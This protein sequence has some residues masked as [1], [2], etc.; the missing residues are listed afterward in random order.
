MQSSNQ[1]VKLHLLLKYKSIP[2]WGCHKK[3]GQPSG[4]VVNYTCLN[5]LITHSNL[6]WLFT[7]ISSHYHPKWS[8]WLLSTWDEGRMLSVFQESFKGTSVQIFSICYVPRMIRTLKNN[9][10]FFQRKMCFRG[11]YIHAKNA[12]CMKVMQENTEV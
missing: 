2:T 3:P 1:K 5:T 12:G 9:E 8:L 7:N 4:V 11:Q 10:V 6:Y